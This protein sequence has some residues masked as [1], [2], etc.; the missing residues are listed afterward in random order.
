MDVAAT[1]AGRI[2][3]FRP[4]TSSRERWYFRAVGKLHE[5]GRPAVAASYPEKV[6]R[7]FLGERALATQRTA[8]SLERSLP[9]RLLSKQGFEREPRAAI[10]ADHDFTLSRISCLTASLGSYWVYFARMR[11]TTGRRIG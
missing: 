1:R 2:H 3:N 8:K 9:R 5:H 4:E 11:S 10:F 7:V 6:A